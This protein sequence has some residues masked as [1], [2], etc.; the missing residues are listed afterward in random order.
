MHRPQRAI[1]VH[2]F[3]HNLDLKPS[4]DNGILNGCFRRSKSRSLRLIIKKIGVSNYFQRCNESNSMSN[5]PVFVIFNLA[6][7]DA[8]AYCQY[9]KG[10]FPI[11]KHYD[12][13][14][15]TCDEAP[16]HL[17]GDVP[18]VGGMTFA[19]APL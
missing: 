2:T 17:E 14:F 12:G 6:V 16:N 18:L 15:L 9:E 5:I 7:T 8:V 1:R 19:F 3:S 11:L 4:P 13:E 10:L